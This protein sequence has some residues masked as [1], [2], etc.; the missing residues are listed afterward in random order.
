MSLATQRA[1]IK[2]KLES[3]SGI[4]AVKDHVVWTDDWAFILAN[5]RDAAQERVHVWFIGLA[6]SAPGS[7]QNGLRVRSYT[8]NII[9][10]YSLATSLES[11]KTFETVAD[12]ILASF[13]G[14]GSI[15]A[16]LTHTP[17]SL[18]GISNVV[19]TEQA[20][21]TAQIQLT[22]DE[23]SAIAGPCA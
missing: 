20:C 6:S 15:G 7:F 1:A 18:Q 8:W 3:V 17:P 23:K 12:A 4:G 22:I 2:A 5:F 9:G 11:S 19:F 13:D 14:I 21:H 10:Y 16:G